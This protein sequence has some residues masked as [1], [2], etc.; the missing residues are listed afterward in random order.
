[1]KKIGRYDIIAELGQGA[2]GV[3]YRASDPTASREV[4][5]KVLSLSASP[6]GGTDSPQRIFMREVQSAARLA[7]PSIVTIYD[8]FEDAETQSS[9]VAMEMVPG[10]TLEKILESP[11]LP[12]TEE[13]FNVVRQVAEGLD[14]AHQNQ[15]IHRDL[16]PAN[17]LVTMDGRV[18]ITDFGIAKVLARQSAAT[19]PATATSPIHSSQAGP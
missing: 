8:A 1:M 10:V 9:C 7:H 3:V 17:I 2:M 13:I 11:P 19:A 5:L 12:T 15:V 6:E 4:A 16:K 14:Y 18:K